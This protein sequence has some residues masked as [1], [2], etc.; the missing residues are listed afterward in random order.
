MPPS[1]R[2]LLRRAREATLRLPVRHAGRGV[3]GALVLA[4][5]LG[6][7]L[8]AP[9]LAGATSAPAPATWRT[10]RRHSRRPTRAT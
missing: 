10:G 9:A 1:A 3:V 5:T 6:L 7:I 2:A 8:F 4:L